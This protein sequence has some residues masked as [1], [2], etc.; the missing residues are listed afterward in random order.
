LL[1]IPLT[2]TMTDPLVAFGATTVME[3]ALQLETI[4][5]VPLN[6]TLLVPWVEPKLVPLTT[7]VVPAVPRFGERDVIEGAADVVKV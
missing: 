2:V 4:A 7:T 3:L 5:A 1:W 6:V